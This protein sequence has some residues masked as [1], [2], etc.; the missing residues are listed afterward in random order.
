[1]RGSMRDYASACGDEG[2]LHAI[3]ELVTAGFAGS[4]EGPWKWDELW[5]AFKRYRNQ[6]GETRKDDLGDTPD[7]YPG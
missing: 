7:L 6:Q 5:A 3:D 1:M 2:L 4:E